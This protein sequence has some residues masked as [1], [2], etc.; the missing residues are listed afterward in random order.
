MGNLSD[1]EQDKAD[2]IFGRFRRNKTDFN[3]A[4]TELNKL[5]PKEPV[6]LLRPNRII[7]KKP[8][9]KP[10]CGENTLELHNIVVL[11]EKL[12]KLVNHESKYP[13]T[14]EHL[15]EA[16]QLAVLREK[17]ISLRKKIFT[18]PAAKCRDLPAVK[19]LMRRISEIREN[20]GPLGNADFK[21]IL[22]GS[23]FGI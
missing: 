6:L 5:L 19:E 11:D 18:D 16:E 23:L 1:S 21:T 7:L 3:T 8:Q 4:L 12:V 20:G 10:C 15:V 22:H 14:P 2:A 9:S 13:M 17:D